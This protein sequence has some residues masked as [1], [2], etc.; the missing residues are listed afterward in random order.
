MDRWSLSCEK[1][2]ADRR[3]CF[4]G[5]WVPPSDHDMVDQMYFQ[6]AVESSGHV[7]MFTD[8]DGTIQYV[9]STF[10]ETTGYDASEA[11]GSNPS[12]LR[13]GVHDDELYAD[14]WETISS[15]NVWEGE[16]VNKRKNGET[17]VIEQTIA[18]I[19][20][21]GERHGYVAINIEITE[22]WERE[23]SIEALHTAT[24]D[25]LQAESFDGVATGVGEAITAI[26]GFPINVVRLRDDNQLVPVHVDDQ[27]RDLLGDRPVYDIDDSLVG[28][29]FRA[30]EPRVYDDIQALSDTDTDTETRGSI[31]SWLYVPLGDYGII[32]VGQTAPNAFTETD[33]QLVEILGMNAE[34]ALRMLEH[35]Q[36]LAHENE[37]LER[38]AQTV[39]HDLRNPL[40][41]AEGT[42]GQMRDFTE[43]LDR[44]TRAHKRME[45]V[46]EGV[47]ML[48]RQGE[49]VVDPAPVDM[50]A[51]AT[52]S[53]DYVE[54]EAATLSVETADTDDLVVEADAMR[55]RHLFENLFRNAITHGGA[56]AVTVG[57]LDSGGFFVADNGCGIPTEQFEQVFRPGYSTA[58]Q[59][60]GLGLSIVKEIAD[61]HGWTASVTESS[62]GG[63]QFEFQPKRSYGREAGA[64]Q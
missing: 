22:K 3:V 39:S 32:S 57:P 24:R 18:P 33:T 52:E 25:L 45:E 6:E 14:M 1:P 64:G 34:S 20:Q 47:L 42:L 51:L 36:E 30:G 28:E 37:R 29:A 21:D 12:M 60:T 48:A 41:V 19:T 15:G 17:Y 55:S 40:N 59:G 38:F 23:R 35:E 56:T 54:T 2:C 26:L 10:E 53:W 43:Q 5:G 63:A 44:M 9:N 49:R 8:L 11:I 62:A 31:R 58:S 16:L 61:A 4:D 50:E 7:V 27:T 13:S 46:I